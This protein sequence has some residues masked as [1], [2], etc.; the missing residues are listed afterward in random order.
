MIAYLQVLD[1]AFSLPYALPFPTPMNVGSTVFLSQKH[2]NIFVN[3]ANI[4]GGG[5]VETMY[6]A[7]VSP[8]SCK[9]TIFWFVPN[10]LFHDCRYTKYHNRRYALNDL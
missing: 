7:R 5:G 3:I 4:G 1:S 10:K 6:L 9:T 2:F 8:L